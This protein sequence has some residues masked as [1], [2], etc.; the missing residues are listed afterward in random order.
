M[1]INI[2]DTQEENTAYNSYFDITQV[3]DITAKELHSKAPKWCDIETCE[4]II[5]LSKEYQISSE[6]ALAV[7]CY[8]YVPERNSVGGWKNSNNQYMEFNS[9][10]ASIKHW[11]VSMSETY[12]NPDSWHYSQT[13]STRLCD[14]SPLYRNG[15]MVYN[16]SAKNWNDC[17]LERIST[18]SQ[19]R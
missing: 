19:A 10:K 14:I 17:V 6:F 16:E 1:D 2:I 8:E 9:L 11:F 5:E 12:C 13:K 3:S 4:Y 15:N 18:Y 7:F